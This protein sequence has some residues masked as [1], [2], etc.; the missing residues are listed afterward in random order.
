MYILKCKADDDDV[1]VFA[2][3][4]TNFAPCT[5]LPLLYTSFEVVASIFKHICGHS[6]DIQAP[7]VLIMVLVQLHRLE[8]LRDAASRSQLRG[9]Q[10]NEL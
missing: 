10:C 4:R 7:P 1:L 6:L 8:L 3:A 5:S 9:A 2:C